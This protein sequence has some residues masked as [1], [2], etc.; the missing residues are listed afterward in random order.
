MPVSLKRAWKG[1]DRKEISPL[2]DFREGPD[3]RGG[4]KKSALWLI[5]GRGQT[6][7]V[8]KRNQPFG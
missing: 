5:L 1:P 4:K 2:A 3:C 7:E 6:A 8:A